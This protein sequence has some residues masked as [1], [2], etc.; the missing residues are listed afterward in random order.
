MT[1][2]SV[3]HYLF[4]PDRSMS[5]LAIARAL[6]KVRT[7][8]GMTLAKVGEA[9]GCSG[10]TVADASNELTLLSFD[11]VARLVFLFPDQCGPI[12]DLWNREPSAKS[13]E[14]HRAAIEHHTAAL[15]RMATEVRS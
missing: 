11:K 12:F 7:L 2:G 13:A 15:A 9:L 1:G 3:P 8:D 5:L 6:L 10:D 14:E 4:A